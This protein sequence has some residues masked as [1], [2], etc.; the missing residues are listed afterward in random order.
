M[1]E[2]IAFGAEVG[3]PRLAG[4]PSRALGRQGRGPIQQRFPLRLQITNPERWNPYDLKKSEIK[5]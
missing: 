2:G 4:L 5:P 3:L 1:L